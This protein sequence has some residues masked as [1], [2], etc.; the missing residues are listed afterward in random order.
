MHHRQAQA[1]A[2]PHLLG[3]EERVEDAIER[4]S[5]H[6]GAR[7]ANC[8]PGIAPGF[9]HRRKSARAIAARDPVQRERDSSST[10]GHGVPGVGAEVQQHLVELRRVALH[11]PQLG[12]EVRL[13]VYV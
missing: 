7:V 9:E 10:S 13:D 1:R 3:R 4:R 5:I 6:A 8:E 12:R 2:L 11:G